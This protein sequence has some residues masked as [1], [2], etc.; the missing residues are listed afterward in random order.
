MLKTLTALFCLISLIS[1]VQ[2]DDAH[3]HGHAKPE[4]KKT[5]KADQTKFGGTIGSGEVVKLAKVMDNYSSFSG[6]PVVFEGTPKKVCKKSGCWMVV[7]DGD[8]EVRTLFKDYGFFV[9]ADI[10][11]KKIR[12]QGMMEQKKVSAGTIRHFMKDEGKS[13]D[14]IKKVKTSQIQFQFV[15]DAVEII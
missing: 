9:P 1:P 8:K 3:K 12:V 6:K 5:A 7:K 4:V 14:D 10:L 13:L 11:G 15:A 2:A